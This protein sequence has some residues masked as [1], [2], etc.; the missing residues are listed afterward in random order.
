MEPVF[1]K[2]T[3]SRVA[4]GGLTD[5]FGGKYE[6]GYGFSKGLNFGEALSCR[7]SLT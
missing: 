3:I 4:L 7:F 2:Y 6:H 1:K 5:G